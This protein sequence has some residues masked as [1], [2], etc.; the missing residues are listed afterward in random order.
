M[1][2]TILTHLS[3]T[4]ALVFVVVFLT[5]CWIIRSQRKRSFPPSIPWMPIVGSLPWMG[6]VEETFP[7][8]ANKYGDIFCF[9]LFSRPVVVLWGYQKIKE[10]ITKDEFAD[11]PRTF[12]FEELS[13]HMGIS[14]SSGS[15]WKEHRTFALR[16]LRDFGVGKKSLQ[17]K[18]LEEVN[19]CLQEISKQNGRPYDIVPIIPM[20]VSNILCN[21]L[22]GNRFELDDPKFHKFIHHFNVNVKHV[23]KA[24]IVDFFPFLRYVPG[25]PFWINTIMENMEDLEQFFREKIQQSKDGFDPD[26]I[27]SYID[28]YLLEASEQKDN[29][30]STFS[31]E[32]LVKSLGDLFAAGTDTTATT[33]RWGLLYLMEYQDVQAKI[34]QEIDEVIGQDRPPSMEDKQ[35]MPFTEACIN[36]MQRV[37]N[38]VP[39]NLLHATRE[40]VN[41]HGYHI[42]KGTMVMLPLTSMLWDESVFPN[43]RE[44][45]PEHFLN[46]D[47]SVKKTDQF[48]P[49]STGR[50]VCLGESLAKMELFI[51]LTSFLQR[52][53]FKLPEGTT[54]PK[55]KRSPYS[56]ITAPGYYKLCAVAR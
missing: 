48:L 38:I 26:D 29:P 8:M 19:I 31:D 34:Q 27:K 39:Q 32:Q 53:T 15:L 51:F 25:D 43:A 35:N 17:G 47:G 52:F 4:T 44:F 36:E 5:T 45:N 22:F 41:F 11:R 30:D 37:S 13:K 10:A 49:F 12:L 24:V 33:L 55:F 42:P 50:R 1:F 20:C 46:D 2:E 56:I 6:L 40:D 54:I 16:S 18:I 9:Y 21:I 23:S 7:K 3:L 14:G 28:A